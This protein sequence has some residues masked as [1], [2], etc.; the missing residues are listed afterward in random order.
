M[1]WRSFRKTNMMM[2]K[3]KEERAKV[4]V[5]RLTELSVRSTFSDFY[6]SNNT[7]SPKNPT[8]VWACGCYMISVPDGFLQVKWLNK[9]ESGN[10]AIL[11]GINKNNR[12]L[13][14]K[15]TQDKQF[16]FHADCCV[17]NNQEVTLK[18]RRYCSVSPKDILMQL[19]LRS[20]FGTCG[21]TSVMESYGSFCFLVEH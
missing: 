8:R 14:E 18:L 13:C 1:Q 4:S 12:S 16:M 7:L 17:W 15:Q 6:F 20:C 10:G 3:K 5:S 19:K 21:K 11:I 9:C 2:M